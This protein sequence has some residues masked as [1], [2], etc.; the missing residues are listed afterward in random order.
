MLNVCRGILKDPNDAEDAFQA[1]FLILV[2]K[3]GTFRGPVTLGP[4]LYQVAFRVAIRANAVVLRRRVCER[5]AGEM[6]AATSSEP[7]LPDEHWKPLHEELARPPE[8]FRRPLVLCDL[9]RVP[10]D[11]AARDLSLSQR[12]LQRRLSAVR[13]RLKARLIRR[14]L[15]PAGGAILASTVLPEAQ[16]AVPP[17]WGEAIVRA[18]L[19]ML[20][21]TTT[22]GIVSGSAMELTH[23]VAKTL[24]LHTLAMTSSALLAAGL[25]AWAHSR[26]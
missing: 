4:W 8:K 15:V 7:V 6:A 9:Q 24:L 21:H 10:Q 18:A 22:A 25:I 12:T 1:T 13:V 17:E 20:N 16:A 2:K 26:R 5:R 23:G 19:A 3:A 14:G 11:L